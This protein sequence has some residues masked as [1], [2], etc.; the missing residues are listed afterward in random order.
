[1][2]FAR[3]ARR[4]PRIGRGWARF[5]PGAVFRALLRFR[6]TRRTLRAAS[7]FWPRHFARIVTSLRREDIVSRICLQ[8][9]FGALPAAPSEWTGPVLL[10]GATDDPLLGARAQEALRERFPRAERHAFRGTRHAAAVPEP[11]A[12]AHRILEFCAATPPTHQVLQQ[13]GA[14]SI[15]LPERQVVQDQDH[16]LDGTKYPAAERERQAASSPRQR[17]DANERGRFQRI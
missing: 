6:L 4:P 11:E 13:A 9:A 12:Y 8:S 5:L 14:D 7:P 17:I 15:M 10:L 1:M 2:S 3:T 16:E